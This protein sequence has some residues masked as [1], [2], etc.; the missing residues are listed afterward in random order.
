MSDPKRTNTQRDTARPVPKGDPRT[1][2][3]THRLRGRELADDFVDA[4]RDSSAAKIRRDDKQSD[5]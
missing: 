1:G 5:S 3:D 4:E 2:A